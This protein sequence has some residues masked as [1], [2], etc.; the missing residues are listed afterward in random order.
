MKKL[1]FN[2]S[3]II[4]KARYLS[5]R[6]VDGVSISLPFISF[7]IKP[8]DTECRVANEVVIRLSDRRVLNASECCDNCIDDALESLQGIREI[9]VDKQVEL[10]DDKN[11]AL[12]L[13]L[14]MMVEGLRQFLTFEQR[15]GELHRE[16]VLSE[17]PDFRRN[18]EARENYFG[19]LETLRGHLRRCLLEIAKIGDVTLPK[20]GMAANYQ[21]PWPIDDYVEPTDISGKYLN[22]L[23]PSD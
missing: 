8:D 20:I 6:R 19:A 12:Y 3:D 13:L 16:P 10:Y 9:I 2:L 14:D 7:K 21:L 4:G 5:K 11:G 17:L 1:K 23:A 22:F 18:P 15:L